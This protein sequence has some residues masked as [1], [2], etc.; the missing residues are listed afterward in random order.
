[1][2][3]GQAPPGTPEAWEIDDLSRMRRVHEY[4]DREYLEIPASPYQRQDG[5][6]VPSTRESS[7][8]PLAGAPEPFIA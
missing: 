3:E 7:S 8:K 2:T 1:M 4:L 5:G 6:S